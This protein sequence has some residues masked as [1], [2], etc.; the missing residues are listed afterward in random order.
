MYVYYIKK[1][2]LFRSNCHRSH[3]LSNSMKNVWASL[4]KL[5]LKLWERADALNYVIMSTVS[6]ADSEYLKT[7]KKE[8]EEVVADILKLKVIWVTE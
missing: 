3:S 8:C 4:K 6:S 2:L 7:I 1:N 5:D